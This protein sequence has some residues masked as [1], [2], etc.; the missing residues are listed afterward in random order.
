MA[1][2]DLSRSEWQAYSSRVSK[3]LEGKRA[4]IEVAALPIGHQIAAKWVPIFGITYD[5]R[6]DVFE[7]AV[8]GLDHLIDKPRS[9][10][11]DEGPTGLRS[12]EIVDGDGQ[13]Q[14]I[15][16]AEPLMLPAPTR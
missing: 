15:Q 10:T 2:R 9:V 6:D 16:L 12:L 8:E 14:I 7:V 1:I 3:S 11:V 4:H 5:P 13:K